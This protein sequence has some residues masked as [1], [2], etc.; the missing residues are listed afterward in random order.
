MDTKKPYESPFKIGKSYTARNS[1][2]VVK[3]VSKTAPAVFLVDDK[4]F[5]YNFFG[6]CFSRTKAEIEGKKVTD[7]D[8]QREATFLERLINRK[9]FK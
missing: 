1:K 4:G 8:L 7:F 3:L 5:E 2:R 6:W 9:I